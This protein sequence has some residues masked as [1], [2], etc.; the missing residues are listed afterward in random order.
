MNGS[1]LSYSCSAVFDARWC[2][3]NT[4]DFGSLFHGSNPCLAML[5]FPAPYINICNYFNSNSN[6][7][8]N[9][10]PNKDST[11]STSVNASSS[12]SYFLVMSILQ[13]F[14]NKPLAFVDILHQVMNKF[15]SVLGTCLTFSE[16]CLIDRFF[17]FTNETIIQSS[18][19]VLLLAK[20]Y[21]L[22][23][24]L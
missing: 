16:V 8:S 17:Y 23:L 22:L 11:D 1:L 7:N 21:H 15:K 6:Y 3:G 10:L 19:G 5:M 9:D 4:S 13:V 12:S 14:K 2:K 24:H 18:L 20:L